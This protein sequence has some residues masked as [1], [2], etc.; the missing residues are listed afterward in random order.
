[1]I[2]TRQPLLTFLVLVT[3]RRRQA[4]QGEELLLVHLSILPPA[5]RHC[6]HLALHLV[7]GLIRAVPPLEDIAST[8]GRILNI[9]R[10]RIVDVVLDSNQLV[11]HVPLQILQIAQR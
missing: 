4:A 7:R 5:M 1:M 3:L 10:L 6:N 11:L 8:G 2:S 9:L